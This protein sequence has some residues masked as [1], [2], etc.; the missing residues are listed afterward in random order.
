MPK[1]GE[2]RN[3]LYRINKTDQIMLNIFND[4]KLTLGFCRRIFTS[5]QP[6]AAKYRK[7]AEKRVRLRICNH[8][9]ASGIG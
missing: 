2:N 9:Q 1:N 3:V 4:K 8:K 7:R 5:T 6:P